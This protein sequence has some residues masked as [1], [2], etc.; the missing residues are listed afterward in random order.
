[1]GAEGRGRERRKGRLWLVCK[2][3]EKMLIEKEEEK[4]MEKGPGDTCL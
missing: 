1:M 3:K 2:I 4:R